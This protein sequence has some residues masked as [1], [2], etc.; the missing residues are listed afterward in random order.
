VPFLDRRSIIARQISSAWP[1]PPQKTRK[2]KNTKIGEL[3]AHF[4]REKANSSSGRFPR[5]AKSRNYE[6]RILKE[7]HFPFT[8][9]KLTRQYLAHLPAFPAAPHCSVIRGSL[10][11]QTCLGTSF[12]LCLAGFLDCV[13]LRLMCLWRVIALSSLRARWT[14]ALPIAAVHS[15]SCT[16]HCRTQQHPSRSQVSWSESNLKASLAER[17]RRLFWRPGLSPCTGHSFLPW[18]SASVVCAHREGVKISGCEQPQVESGLGA[19]SSCKHEAVTIISRDLQPR[20]PGA[21]TSTFRFTKSHF[22]C[23]HTLSQTHI[24]LLAN[25]LPRLSAFTPKST[26]KF[27]QADHTLTADSR[28]TVQASDEPLRP[29]IYN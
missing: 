14:A 22:L 5:I 20:S 6:R 8:A 25:R 3:G 23:P 17:R 29:S 12:L 11:S 24:I 10:T 28:Q 18:P 19:A 13:Q 16:L 7:G 27:L 21:R 2:A 9:G 15:A 4:W 1:S 26:R